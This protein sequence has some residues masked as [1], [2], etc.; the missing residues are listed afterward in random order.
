MN[1]FIKV[2]ICIILLTAISNAKAQ[3]ITQAW[4][5]L[6]NGTNPYDIAIDAA[7]N[8]YTTNN[9]NS[10]V[11]KITAAGIVTQTWATLAN[12]ASP[13]GIAL[14]AAGNVYTANYGN[15][16]VSKI[17][18][19]GIVTQTWA[20]I[21]ND[22]RP[23]DIAI[24]AS[25][26]VYTANWGNNTV[27][28]I[29]AGGTITQE[30][31]SLDGKPLCIAIDASGNVYTCN[32]LIGTV[33]KITANGI[34][35]Q[36]WAYLEPRAL[37][38]AITVDA[39]GNVY[40][41]DFNH[42]TINK[43][44]PQGVTAE[45]L[46]RLT[47]ATINDMVMDASGNFYTIY[48]KSDFDENESTIVSKITAR[49]TVTQAWVRLEGTSSSKIVVDASGNVYTANNG[50]NTIS[51]ISINNTW[52]GTPPGNT[53]HFDG[54]ND[55]VQTDLSPIDIIGNYTVE[56]WVKPNDLGNARTILSTRS[57]EYGLDLKLSGGNQIHADI[58]NGSSW[59]TTNADAA[60]HYIA[61]Q[62]F[63]IAYVVT[64]S[65]YTIYANGKEVGAGTFSD[66][67]LL[68]NTSRNLIIGAVSTTGEFFGGSIDEVKVYNAALTQAQIKADMISTSPVL[69]ANIKFYY[70]FD[71]G[72]AGGI[73]TGINTLND[74]VSSYNGTVNNFALSGST[75]NWVESYAMVLPVSTAATGIT[76]SGFTANWT[77]P[78]LGTV[79]NYKLDVSTSP[80]FASAVTGSPFTISGTSQAI[81][82]L[83]QGTA[84]YYR[85]RADKA[86]V[87][88]Q[89]AYSDTVSAT[90]TQ[91]ISATVLYVDGNRATSGSGKSWATA[92]KTL[93]EALTYANTNVIIDSILIAK[94]TY[95]PTGLQNGTDRD[96][97][98]VVLRGK[99]KIYGGYP[100]G[101][102][103]RDTVNNKVF[104]DG[105]IG[106]GSDNTDNSYHVMA[107]VG[108]I[109][110]ADSVVVDG[111]TIR[112][113]NANG[114][115]FGG[116]NSTLVRQYYGGGVC[117]IG[118]TIGGK[119]LFRNCIFSANS[120][121]YNG[122]GMYNE[123][124][125]SPTIMNCI[126]SENQSDGGG[127]YNYTSNPTILNCLFLKNRSTNYAG[128]G[129]MNDNSSPIVIN[130]I[131]SG[132]SA[133]TFGGGIYN[134]SSN[135]I[136][137]NTI[138]YNN[139]ATSGGAGI[140]NY[141]S[142]P[143]INN[144]LIEGLTGVS[145][146]NI[147]GTTN[148][149]FVNAAAGDF[150]LQAASPCINKG[151]NT[152]YAGSI[153]IDKDLAGN[154]RL[155]GS[156]IDMGVYERLVSNFYFRS[157]QT[158]NWENTATWELSEDST[159]WISTG[160]PP[161]S[162]SLGTTVQNHTITINSPLT[163]DKTTISAT[164]RLIINAATKVIN[165]GLLLQSSNTV[166]ASIGS[167]TGSIAGNV[168]VQRY[169][170]AQRG[171]KL[172]GHPFNTNIVLSSLQPYVDIT[173]S[174]GGFTPGAAGAFNYTTGDWA[175]YAANTQ[176]WNKNE[177]LMLFVRGTPGQGLNMA[178]NYT[179]SAPT[180]VLTGPINQG[181]INY[182]VKSA[183]S[184][185]GAAIGWNAIGNPYPAPINVTSIS[186]INAPGG[187]G[188]SVY[189]WNANKGIT[190]IA[191]AGGGYDF[192]TLG[193][194]IIIPAYGAF[195]IKNTSGI[196]QPLTFTESNKSTATPLALMG[197][198]DIQ[199]FDLV[200]NSN[201]TYWDKLRINFSKNATPAST[202]KEDLDKFSNVNFDLY[203]IATDNK[204]LAVDNRPV[205]Q[206]V[207]DIIPLGIKTNQ[208]RSF[209][210]TASNFNLTGT[211]DVFLNDKLT[212]I[213]TKI[214][215]KLNYD[216]MVTAD[217]ATQGEQRFEIITMQSPIQI[218]PVTPANIK[219]SISPNPVSDVLNI[220]STG[221]TG[222]RIMNMLGQVVK[223]INTTNQTI[224]IPVNDLT[225]GL[226]IVEVKND[227][228]TVT[229]KIVKQ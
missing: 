27:S 214:N 194:N 118:N 105:D 98:F 172:M 10:T 73:N 185:G 21:A 41:T 69:P 120:A 146:G 155:K 166:T 37:P 186:N 145:N 90:T 161:D 15:N 195:F 119:L 205:L 218:L 64:T 126:F 229:E 110:G 75:S 133:N 129:M 66:N 144:S 177:A 187:S 170:T 16:T 204:H 47:N 56:A 196:D 163:I 167:S 72:T 91:I 7:G 42:Y 136:I 67:P 94:G 65:G 95:Y 62:W 193:N 179:P 6:A 53:L 58:G 49:G 40:I 76:G 52:T 225:K 162:S 121:D 206:S 39:S 139:T 154:P 44:T 181:N 8:V 153:N 93:S 215:D 198:N 46:A 79:D 60:Y 150:R 174:G 97:A 207:T 68:I 131:F 189:I 33:S 188:A 128:G 24:D 116:Y 221:N 165:N 19:A 34:L 80:T 74:Q 32:D 190:D 81:T 135:P 226:Y 108:I 142:T 99:L 224:K 148:P 113:G 61:N 127:M 219:I 112:N 134:Q 2:C 223:T 92:Y 77:A 149:L 35:T 183:A 43:I 100:K 210:I 117:N 182:T 115:Y 222:I 106:A 123:D 111:V 96:S 1:K 54:V 213:K 169:L 102:G 85:V 197:V 36:E 22:G 228:E 9:G 63:H 124:N 152:L 164:G 212:G 180:I 55:Y 13:Y 156:S 208:T 151:S 23:Y 211:Y 109:N 71:N 11:S 137:S 130:C 158:G 203:S 101:G 89:G 217:K 176:T 107:I 168:S 51:K 122:G 84:Y 104:L 48:G 171:Y 83:A 26:N 5:T 192:Y 216:F 140:S 30:W 3:T 159:S 184:F 209:T 4:A 132:N 38:T 59:V 12:G 78:A 20:T 201:T 57:L 103:N 28:K 125:S 50:D 29:T 87:A 82:G 191:L 70:N 141:L 88:G 25:G 143:V 200:I 147:N 227:K 173:G 18:A 202:D 86:S 199:G 160:V 175:A 138:A 114:N 157:K 178:G 14:D 220:T 45:V 17:T 31:A